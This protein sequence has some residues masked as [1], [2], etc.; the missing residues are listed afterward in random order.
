MSTDGKIVSLHKKNYNKEIT[1]SISNKGYWI[2]RLSRKGKQSVYYIHRLLALAFI[3]N[4][5][6]KMFVNHKNGNKLDY[7]ITNL[8]W[9][10]A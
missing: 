1:Q 7:S 3:P 5:L 2:V 4:P 10:T 8:E 9:V 6:N